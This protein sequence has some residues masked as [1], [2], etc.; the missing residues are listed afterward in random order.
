[1]RFLITKEAR[2]R[3]ASLK[4]KL[5]FLTDGVFDEIKPESEKVGED[6]G[7]EAQKTRC[8]Q[9]RAASQNEDE[10]ISGP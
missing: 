1:M 7:R 9:G 6:E 5:A 10:G 3:L 2:M 4:A 8:A